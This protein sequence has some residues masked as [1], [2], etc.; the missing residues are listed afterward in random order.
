VIEAVINKYLELRA[1]TG[2]N[3]NGRAEHFIET[4]RRVGHDGFKAAANSVRHSEP[5]IA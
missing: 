2:N 3:Q 4:L 5:A 1:P